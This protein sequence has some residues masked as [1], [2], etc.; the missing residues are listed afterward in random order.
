MAHSG[1]LAAGHLRVDQVVVTGKPAQRASVAVTLAPPLGERDP[2]L[3]LRGRE[4]LVSELLGLCQGG[5][6]GRLHV[7]HGLGGC[8]KTAVVLEAVHRLLEQAS[9][10]GPLVWWIDGRHEAT[11]EAGLRAVARQAGLRAK[12]IR[13]EDA[14]DA[15]WRRLAHLPRRWV[16]VLD[17]V[18]DP[19]LLDGPG[20]LISGTGWVRPTGAVGGLVIVTSRQGAMSAWGAAAVLHAVKPLQAADAAHMLLDRAGD[21]AGDVTQARALGARLGGLPLAL[22]LAGSFL[23]EASAVPG[24]FRALGT[25]LD[26]ASYRQALEGGRG[27]VDAVRVVARSRHLA[28]E[29][30]RQRGF[31][32]AGRLL[33]VLASFADAPLPPTL[34]LRPAVLAQTVAGFD[35][36]D[37]TTLW[38]MLTEL[39]ALGLLELEVPTPPAGGLP[40]VRLHPLVRDASR[41]RPDV[42]AALSLLHQ[43]ADLEGLYPPEE[44]AHWPA[45]QLLAPHTLELA[46][47]AG[48]DTG[49]DP[50]VRLAGMDSAELGARYLQSQGMFEQACQQLE[51]VLAVRRRLLGEDH[52]ETL[53][54]GHNLAGAL[55]DL[56]HLA[57]ARTAYARIWV[58]RQ[59]LQ[60]AEHGDTLTARHELA[61]VLHDQGELE[62]ARV[63]FEQILTVRRRLQGDEHAHTLAAR[64]E[65]A[66][67]LHDQGELEQ[68]RQ[69]YQSILELR[70][71]TLGQ[72][73]PRTLTTRHNLACLLHDAG[74][75]AQ[76]HQELQA[77]LAGRT[78][79][80]GVTH[81]QTLSTQYKLARLLKET[82]HQRQALQL[83]QA[84]A[85]A[86]R[87]TLGEGHP[88]TRRMTGTLDAWTTN[89]HG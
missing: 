16:L 34:L 14:A 20:R 39:A 32:L 33:E 50:P 26:F 46:R 75:L 62:Q 45:W 68:A 12:E 9:D 41:E 36:V 6:G 59:Q 71:H 1:G 57:P 77:T 17:S 3:P 31:A 65:L 78:T 22:H 52:P 4:T 86:A 23:A 5:G 89:A 85:D 24:A 28:V 2:R 67:I 42:A 29:L 38:R 47:Q 43:G 18:D 81:P 61:R 15:L 87:R 58:A 63:H 13:G 11:V 35:T 82:G 27:P 84:A 40:V 56:G 21:R 74:E 49:L 60:G 80:L 53:S 7:V 54:A 76:A 70:H 69:E 48:A 55:H 44:P 83:L 79:V 10:S 25:P 73:H 37:G 66:R 51:Q 19:S 30:L 72:L 8:G 64:H 88:L